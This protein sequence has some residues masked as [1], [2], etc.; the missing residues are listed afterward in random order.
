MGQLTLGQVEKI[1]AELKKLKADYKNIPI[2]LG[3]D[4]ELNGIHHAW[5][6]VLY[7]TENKDEDTK[8]IL[9]TMS[10]DCEPKGI[11]LLIS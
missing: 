10:S 4:D 6:A 7:H 5:G 9:E 3:D 11:F 1:I 2:Y 8:F